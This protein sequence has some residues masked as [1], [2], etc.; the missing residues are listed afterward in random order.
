MKFIVSIFFLLLFKLCWSQPTNRE[1]KEHKIKSVAVT[2]YE[3]AGKKEYT[4]KN[5]YAVKGYDSLEYF[6]ESISFKYAPKLNKDGTVKELIRTD[7][8]NREDEWHIYEY[9]KN[10]SYTIEIIAHGAGRIF[11]TDYD[12]EGNCISEVFSSTDDT[13]IYSNNLKGKIKAVH[14]KNEGILIEVATSK[15]DAND[16][17][18]ETNISGDTPLIVRYKNNDKGLPEEIK[19]YSK[20]GSEEKLIKTITYKYE[21][22]K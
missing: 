7:S 12:S 21:F 10:G 17:T 20:L 3:E 2:S 15:F 5:Y 9:Q 18:I 6:N 22:Y 14:Q 11:V 8:K 13:L 1:I 16:Y 19:Q 4:Q